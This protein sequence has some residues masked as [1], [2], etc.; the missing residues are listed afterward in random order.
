M[1]IPH[2]G[3][4]WKLPEMP[5]DLLAYLTTAHCPL[6]AKG[7]HRQKT[8]R[9]RHDRPSSK[10]ISA[11]RPF[12]VFSDHPLHPMNPVAAGEVAVNLLE[13]VHHATMSYVKC[14]RSVIPPHRLRIF[15]RRLKSDVLG[16][17][18]ECSANKARMPRFR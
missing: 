3:E 15:L 17:V 10:Y 13:T 5:R 8:L 11:D 2:L 4:H 14:H 7:A 18:A 12:Q 1:K 16:L 6:P 9:F